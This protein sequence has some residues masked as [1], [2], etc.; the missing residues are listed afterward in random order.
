[1]DGYLDFLIEKMRQCDDENSYRKEEDVRILVP[2]IRKE[3]LGVETNQW[4]SN[5]KLQWDYF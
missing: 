5:G 3:N 2:A 4:I 1:M